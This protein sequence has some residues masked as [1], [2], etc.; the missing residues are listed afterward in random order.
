MY[1]NIIK[2]I[3]QLVGNGY[4]YFENELS[5]KLTPHTPPFIAWGACVSPAGV[6]YVMD[7]MGTECG[8]HEVEDN[9]NSKLLI[10]SL[11]QRVRYLND[12]VNTKPKEERA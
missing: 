7:V 9:D 10:A 3:L 4:L 8:W 5:V 1:Q 2:I 6:L 11:F 12:K